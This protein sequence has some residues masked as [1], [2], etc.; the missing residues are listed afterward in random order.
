MASKTQIGA[1]IGVEGASKYIA[2]MKD[3]ARQ[4]RVFKADMEALTTSF[5][6]NEKSIGELGKQKKILQKL[7][8]NENTKLKEQNKLMD[9]IND[10]VLDGSITTEKWVT[11]HKEVQIEIDKTTANVN[12]LQKQLDE[13]NKQNAFTLMADAWKNTTSE[14][15]EVLKGIGNTFTKYVTL[16]IIGGATASVKVA[17]DFES[18]FTG[19]KKTVDEIVDKNDEVVYSYEQLEAE[20][21]KIPLETASTYETVMGVAEAAGQ[22]GVVANEIPE[23]ARTI[24]MLA[25]STNISAE[26]GAVSMAQ[27]LNIMG[28]G[29]ETASQFGSALVELGNNTATDEASILAL[30]TRMAS[31]GRSIKLSTAD[32][33]GLAAAMSA[34][35][36]TAEAGG[37]AMSTTIQLITKAVASGSE[38]V[39]K[40]A[41]LTGMSAEQFSETWRKEPIKALQALLVGMG[42]LEGGGEELIVLLDELGWAGIRQSDLIRRLTLD[43]DGVESAVGMANEAYGKNTA[44]SDEASKRYKDFASELSQ[45]KESVK[46]L[47]DA[48]GKELIPILKPIVDDATEMIKK[49][50]DMDEKT[51][52]NIMSFLGL[53]AAAGPLI[54]AI[55]NIMIWSAKLKAAFGVLKGVEGVGGLVS[56]LGGGAAK[57]GL[58]GSLEGLATTITDKAYPALIGSGTASLGGALTLLGLSYGGAYAAAS[59][60]DQKMYESAEACEYVASRYHWTEEKVNEYGYTWDEN[61]HLVELANQKIYDTTTETSLD[62]MEELYWARREA[63]ATT[64]GATNDVKNAIEYRVPD[65]QAASHKM[66]YTAVEEMR[67]SASE[68]SSYGQSLGNNFANGISATI[69]NVRN[70]VHGIARTVQSYLHFSEPDTGPL[71]NFNSWMPDMMANMA[72]GI[73]DNMYLVEG[74]LNNLT[75]G[76]A[77]QLG[78]TAYNYGGVNI[79]LNVPQG[80]NGY[81]MVDEIESAL[82]QRTVRRKAVFA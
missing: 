30:A 15:G 16:P 56:A 82:A 13:L 61:G 17:T 36:V 26:E 54:S 27:F 45:F 1:V 29:T 58:I 50:A 11:A 39:E 55:G 44:L 23:F 4:T 72:K 5:D 49:F 76:M 74:A 53:A 22:L 34:V 68:A 65:V 10:S 12:K 62:V 6:K 33:L 8:D 69:N 52:K 18:A 43:Y 41:K 25:D 80:A 21:R 51:K 7:I 63:K 60:M 24:I 57:G 67:S 14:T 19:V 46:Q 48:F 32:I 66:V 40:F 59:A 20:L 38:D 64:E 73:N 75:G 37:T 78:G 70:A 42:N 35:G 71:S 31:A 79:I 81:Q 3:L 28:E 2:T 9:Q 47:A 77:N